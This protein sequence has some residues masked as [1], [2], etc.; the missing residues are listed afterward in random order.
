MVALTNGKQE[1]FYICKE[2]FRLD[3]E[4]VTWSKID[5]SNNEGDLITLPPKS[6]GQQIIYKD[7]KLYVWGAGG[8]IN[9]IISEM[10][11]YDIEKQYW[12]KL[13]IKGKQEDASLVY[14]F[15]SYENS[16]YVVN[17]FDRHANL[18]HKFINRLNLENLEWEKYN[19]EEE[20]MAFGGFGYVCDGSMVY[21]FAGFTSDITINN[22][23]SIDLSA[24]KLEWN[25]LGKRTNVPTAR[26]GHAMQVYD[27]KLFILG[28]RDKYG[29]M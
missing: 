16:L 17:G 3:I 6:T 18:G 13:D 8:I 20:D 10:Y 25:L 1:L 26:S 12:S 27:D 4:D 5:S 9:P 7:G 29:N 19:V 2:L 28:G 24:Q 23:W 21:L 22:L 15:C 11:A 14:G